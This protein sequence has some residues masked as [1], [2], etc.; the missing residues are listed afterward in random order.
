[1]H[2][3][4]RGGQVLVIQVIFLDLAHSFF[5]LSLFQEGVSEKA[6]VL[7]LSVVRIKIPLAAALQ[8]NS[9]FM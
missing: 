8:E 4:E 1:M 9:K 2:W 6:L 7:I 5:T 3:G